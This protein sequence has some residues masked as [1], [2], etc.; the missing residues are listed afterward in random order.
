MRIHR[1]FIGVSAVLAI[2]LLPSVA[3]AGTVRVDDDGKAS[4]TSCNAATK[5][6][7]TIQAGITA[8]GK[9]GTVILCPGTY[10][11]RVRVD[12]TRDG[13]TIQ[14]AKNLASKVLPPATGLNLDEPLI[15]IKNSADTVT[16]KGLFVSTA[17]GDCTTAELIRL[18]GRGLKVIGNTLTG[19]GCYGIGVK[20]LS[21]GGKAVS[22]TIK[23]NTISRFFTAG[24]YGAD[25]LTTLTVTGNTVRFNMD[26]NPGSSDVT[27]ILMAQNVNGSVADNTV[28]TGSGTERLAYGIQA[29]YGESLPITGNTITEVRIGIRLDFVQL[30]TVTG[31]SIKGG[32]TGIVTGAFTHSTVGSNTIDD[33]DN[34]IWSTD[35]LFNP[36]GDNTFQDNVITNAYE[37]GCRD[38]VS[39]GGE[40]PTG[41][42]PLPGNTWTGNTAPSD[43]PDGICPPPPA[44]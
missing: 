6:P 8:A 18:Q 11:G 44:P 25:E 3:A 32:V 16:L 34:G 26:F 27:G 29:V 1:R 42:P 33:I 23:N 4:A 31:N 41:D 28:A 37:V 24:I 40:D 19:G 9:N 7:R 21:A 20:A 22:A 38:D 5:A 30:M 12:G 36:D 2:G 17:S 39:T 13:I 10:K 15:W 35:N 14:G 43:N